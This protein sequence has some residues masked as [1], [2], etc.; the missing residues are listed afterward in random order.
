[1]NLLDA[2]KK[3]MKAY[4]SGIS[5]KELNGASGKKPKY[6]KTYFDK[7]GRENNIEPYELK[8]GKRKYG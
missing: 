4:Y 2:M 8:K 5:P 6:G 7:V 1:M 3:S